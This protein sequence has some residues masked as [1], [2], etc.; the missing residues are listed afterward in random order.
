[1]WRPPIFAYTVVATRTS[2]VQKRGGV[3]VSGTVRRRS[4]VF[5]SGEIDVV[6]SDFQSLRRNR[7]GNS[8]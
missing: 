6:V 3:N 4:R 5:D 2:A 1:M 7:E 8:P